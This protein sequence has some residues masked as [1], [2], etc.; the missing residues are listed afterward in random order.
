M[1]VGVL[2]EA[3]GRWKGGRYWDKCRCI[4]E[5]LSVLCGLCLTGECLVGRCYHFYEFSLTGT[6]F[7]V[8]TL[9]VD[10]SK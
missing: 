3:W 1:D 2:C 10:N 7:V 8:S 5:M 6:Q 4:R 9:V